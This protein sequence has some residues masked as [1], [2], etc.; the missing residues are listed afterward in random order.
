M[1][2]AAEEV[3]GFE[4]RLADVNTRLALVTWVASTTLVIVLA[5][6]W[7]I[8]DVRARLPLP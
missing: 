6:L 1:K 3:A 4:N 5:L 8:L 2:K 7:L